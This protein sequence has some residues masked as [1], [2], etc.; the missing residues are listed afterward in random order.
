MV[1]FFFQDLQQL[2]DELKKIWTQFYN[3]DMHLIAAT[4]LTSQCI[5]IVRQAEAAV[6]EFYT[7]VN[8]ESQQTYKDL[9]GIVCKEESL[10]ITALGEFVFLPTGRILSKIAQH[11]TTEIWPALLPPVRAEYRESRPELLDDPRMKEFEKQDEFTCQV[12]IDMMADDLL[13]QSCDDPLGYIFKPEDSAFAA[14][15]ELWTKRIVT[16]R[17]VFTAQILWDIHNI[18]SSKGISG[19]TVMKS[20]AEKLQSS[21]KFSERTDGGKTELRIENLPW[22]DKGHIDLVLRIYKRMKAHLNEPAFFPKSK[23]ALLSLNTPQGQQDQQSQHGQQDDTSTVFE[24]LFLQVN[25]LHV[26]LEE[27]VQQ[28]D[29]PVQPNRDISFLIKANPLYAGTIL[30]DVTSMVELDGINV[31]NCQL[32]ITLISHLYNA[33]DKLGLGDTR[34]P[35]L[36]KVIQVH[37]KPIFADDVPSSPKDFLSRFDYR[38]ADLTHD[39]R[40]RREQKRWELRTT[41]TTQALRAFFESEIT[42]PQ[43]MHTLTSQAEAALHGGNMTSSQKGRHAAK[44]KGYRRL[45][46]ETLSALREHIEAAIPVM[47]INYIKLTQ[48]CSPLILDI[49]NRMIAKIDTEQRATFNYKRYDPRKDIRLILEEAYICTEIMNVLDKASKRSPT[50][51]EGLMPTVQRVPI[52][53][54]CLA[55]EI[56]RQSLEAQGGLGGGKAE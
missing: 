38:M 52:V 3:G 56:S 19:L 54:E 4:I 5:E 13:R 17:M 29:G 40:H 21:F 7:S 37:A 45:P 35:E 47:E 2:R 12:C 36:E 41:S 31:E 27:L 43:L 24:D 14:F 18:P 8:K 11:A 51:L 10:E 50:N 22:D 16:T 32:S 42:L 26:K 1:Y 48:Q 15:R 53:M 23:Q 39:S 28:A 34:W 55:A 44:G 20:A 9:Y 46:L 49:K 33:L 6:H 30:M 25:P